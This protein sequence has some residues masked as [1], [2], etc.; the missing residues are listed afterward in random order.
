MRYFLISFLIFLHFDEL[1]GQFTDNFTDGDF[2]AMPTWIGNTADFSVTAGELQ[3]TA[4]AVSSKKYLCTNSQSIDNGIWEFNVRMTFGTSSSNFSKVY[5]A[6]SSSNLSGSLNGYFVLIGGTDDE[7]SLYSQ[8]GTNTTEIIDG[9]NRTIGGSSVNTTVRVTRSNTGVWEVFSDTNSSA[10]SFISEGTVTDNTHTQ[11]LFFG[12]ECNFTSTRSN[13]FYF[14]NFSVSGN[15]AVDNIKPIL[16]SVLVVSSTQL[17]L[18]FSEP[19]DPVNSQLISNYSAN[20][21]LG[22]PISVNQNPFDFSRI[23][24]TFVSPFALGVNNSLSVNNVTDVAGNII[25]STQKN[26]VYFIPSIPN[27]REVVINEIFADPS[28]VIGLPD[29][30]FIELFNPSNNYFELSN[31]EITDGTSNATLPNYTLAPNSF[32]ILCSN[33]TLADFSSYPNAIGLPSFPS[34]NN[35]GEIV[36]LLDDQGTIIDALDYNLAMYRDE[37]KDDGGFTLEQINPQVN[38]FNPSNWTSSNDQ[39][40]G[41][42]GNSNSVLNLSPDTTKPQ[43]ISCFANSNS[44]I[45]L[46]FDK[47]IDTTAFFSNLIISNGISVLSYSL[48]NNFGTSIE[49][50]I[51]PLLDTG[52]VYNLKTDTLMDCDGNLKATATEFVLAHQNKLGAVIINEIL[53]NPYAGDEDFVEFYNNSNNYFNLKNWQIGNDDNGVVGNLKSIEDNYILKPKEYVVVT[54]NSARIK[55]RYPF[56]SESKFIEMESLPTFSN[57]KGTVYLLIPLGDESDKFTYT[58]DLHFD[59]LRDKEG[60]SLERLDI[61]KP[62]QDISNWHSAAEEVGFATPGKQNSQYTPVSKTENTLSITPEIFSPDQDGFEDLLTLS[63]RMPLAGF[64]G[65]V[66][67]FDSKGRQTR[68]LIKNQL[69]AQ[70]GS[71]TWDGTT[72]N[73]QKARIG[74]YIILFEYYD[75]EGNVKSEKTTCVVGHRL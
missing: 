45:N 5:L 63:Y 24:L 39:N 41:T 6:S 3:L 56:H 52:T 34:L 68:A 49:L 38:C 60:V 67:I 40:G 33:T 66:T 28:P 8:T 36:T 14:D 27:Y 21:S 64:V 32:V 10:I 46:T 19:L 31:W 59:L 7:I 72:N 22:N 51:F 43:I 18:V 48:L 17:E 1:L 15:S 20:N 2:T 61:D 44:S 69:L 4:P 42:P 71:F 16:D 9:R 25:N 65:S 12:V 26:F 74:R 47:T 62:T 55:N 29:A 23:S 75:L 13:R 73:N 11:S 30:E 37:V 70:Q 54:K 53:F 58:E 35:S 50:T 57:D